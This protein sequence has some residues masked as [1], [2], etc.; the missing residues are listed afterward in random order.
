MKI[1]E[2][3]K[4]IAR[5]EPNIV[6]LRNHGQELIPTI[7]SAKEQILGALSEVEKQWTNL[8]NLR[9]SSEKQI[10]NS[11]QVEKFKKT[12]DDTTDWVAEKLETID[13]LDSMFKTNPL[14][15]VLRRHKALEREMIPIAQKVEDIK[16][17]YKNVVSSYR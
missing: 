15:N 3:C 6:G 1:D 12:C 17:G 14:D 11:V 10:T 5:Y 9:R 16:L 13:A 8:D 4:S 7:P 2:I